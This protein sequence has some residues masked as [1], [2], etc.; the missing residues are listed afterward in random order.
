MLTFNP[1]DFSYLPEDKELSFPNFDL[2]DPFN[3]LF[4]HDI[5]HDSSP[6]NDDVHNLNGVETFDFLV[7]DDTTS[8]GSNVGDHVFGNRNNSSIRRTQ[9][10]S[11]PSLRCTQSQEILPSQVFQKLARFERPKAAISG[12]EL[13]DLEGKLPPQVLPVRTSVLNPSTVP[14]PPLRRKIRFSADPPETLRHR[15]HKISKTSAIG[16]GDPSRMMRPSYYYRHEMPSFQEWTQRF[17]QI[18][19]QPPQGNLQAPSEALFR[20]ETRPQNMFNA[21]SSLQDP[22]QGQMHDSKSPL[23]HGDLRQ[24]TSR[25]NNLSSATTLSPL[26]DLQTPEKDVASNRSPESNNRETILSA[27]MAPPSTL[28]P[29]WLPTTASTESFDFAISPTQTPLGWP[30]ES[31]DPLDSYYGHFGASQS[32]PSLPQTSEGYPKYV[33]IGQAD[34]YEQFIAED[35]SN[36]YSVTPGRPFHSPNFDVYPPL[37]SPGVPSCRPRSPTS[38]SPSPSPSPFPASKSPSRN[39]RRSKSGRRKCSAG[40]LKSPSSLDFVNFTPG[41]SQRILSGVAPSGSSKTKARREQEAMDRKRKLS[42]AA[43][44]A[45]KEAGGDVEQLRAAGLFASL[46]D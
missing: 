35:P 17:E 34:G 8:S 7:D 44:K 21:P 12:L 39:H 31:F 40:A 10:F 23:S 30:N 19:L 46:E 15:N 45:V 42:L 26:K 41:D 32:A 13:L 4:N 24:P 1:S 2:D 18:S 25:L 29:S 27:E 16:V 38:A 36:D 5:S 22:R 28:S 43:E 14:A 9:R 20:H 33:P 37:P 11:Q 6:S 3:D